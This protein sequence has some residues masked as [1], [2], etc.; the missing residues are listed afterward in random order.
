MKAPKKTTNKPETY[1]T[2]PLMLD[3]PRL[4]AK[5]I[6]EPVL[7]FAGQHEHPDPKTGIPLYGP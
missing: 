1:K 7:R 5:W 2:A 3:S 4:S 6:D